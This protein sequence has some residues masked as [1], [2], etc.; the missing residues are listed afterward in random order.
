M[1]NQF[2]AYKIYAALAEKSYLSKDS[3]I[4]MPSDYVVVKEL[5]NYNNFT[6]FDLLYSDTTKAKNYIA[7]LNESGEKNKIE[8]LNS[9]IKTIQKQQDL[10]EHILE[11]KFMLLKGHF[12]ANQNGICVK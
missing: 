2:G 5:P 12:M 11:A 8:L 9:L 10:S 7:R 4:P 1:S 6:G 3:K